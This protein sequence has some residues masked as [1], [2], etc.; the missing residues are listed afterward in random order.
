MLDS[1]E[2][3]STEQPWS[4]WPWLILAL[5]FVWLAAMIYMSWSEWGQPR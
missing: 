2:H 3:S 5:W 4:P 1:N